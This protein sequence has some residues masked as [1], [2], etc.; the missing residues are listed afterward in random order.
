MVIAIKLASEFSPAWPQNVVGITIGVHGTSNMAEASIHRNYC[1]CNVVCCWAEKK[2]G[3]VRNLGDKSVSLQR[4]IPLASILSLRVAK[5]TEA[6]SGGSGAR[7]KDL[8]ISV[9]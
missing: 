4:N 3:R 1:T 5:T 7:S 8:I 6:L 2:D 9:T